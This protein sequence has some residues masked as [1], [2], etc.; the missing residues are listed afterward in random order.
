MYSNEIHELLISWG[1]YLKLQ[2]NYSNHTVI[3]Y[4]HDLENFLDF[5]KNY[6]GSA[7]TISSI[8]EVDIR[9]IRS[10][11]SKRHQANYIAASNARALSAIKNFYRFL[12]QTSGITCHK[13]FSVKNP[14]KAKTLPKALSQDDTTLSINH[15]EEFGNIESVESRNKALL[16]LLYASGLRISEALSITKKHLNNLTYIKIISKGNRERIVPWIDIAKNLIAQYLLKLPYEIQENDLIFRGKNGK[17]LQP[18]VF[19]RELIKLRRFY[20]L[21]E[22]LRSH[23]F[24]HSF[25]THLLENGSDLRSIQELLGHKSLSTTQ[26]YTKVNS[27]HLEHVYNN[28]HPISKENE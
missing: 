27:K 26:I 5:M 6:S 25:A 2:R 1:R 9:F 15:I 17:P 22:H 11:L 8:Q 7:P 21:P 23:S 10:W 20:G 19:N 18:A 28:S 14:K 24:R 13:I 16:V 3:S 12:E 4:Q